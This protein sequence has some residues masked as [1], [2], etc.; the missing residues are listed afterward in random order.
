MHDWYI[1][2]R[3]DYVSGEPT[4]DHDENSEVLWIDV[5]EALSR[6]DVPDLT[7]KLIQ[8]AMADNAGLQLTEYETTSQPPYSL[9]CL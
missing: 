1:A 6:E 3:A 7:K 2:F 5:K 9:Y 4:S 8:S